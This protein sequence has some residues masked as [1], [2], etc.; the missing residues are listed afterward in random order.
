MVPQLSP[1]PG[2]PCVALAGARNEGDATALAPA[3]PSDE[4]ASGPD[5][6]RERIPLR[7]RR[8]GTLTSPPRSSLRLQR[9]RH[10]FFSPLSTRRKRLSPL[11]RQFQLARTDL[12]AGQ[13]PA[14]RFPP[15][16]PSLL[17]R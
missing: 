16:V 13:L 5:A 1:R 15:T 12:D 3:R 6:R 11:R 14:H 9:Q 7:L 4:K 17:R 8:S 2:E 10:G